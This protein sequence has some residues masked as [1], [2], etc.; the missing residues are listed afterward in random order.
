MHRRNFLRRASALGALTLAGCMGDANDDT[1]SNSTPT[2]TPADE[3]PK[4][5]DSS[6]ETTATGCTSGEDATATVDT[7]ESTLTVSFTGQVTAGTPCHDATI[8]QTEYD[9]D[10]DELTV[11]VGTERR[12]ETCVDCVGLIE[13]AGT[14]TFEGA[15]P[16]DVTITHGDEPLT[17]SGGDSST[18]TEL[19]DRSFTVESITSGGDGR[20]AD[21][22]FDE[23]AGTVVVTG[24][25]VGKDGCATAELGSAIY[26]AD[27][28][29]LH[30]DVVTTRQEGAE[31]KVCT[32]AL[33]DIDYE[34]TFTFEGE[35][36]SSVSISH[37]G[38]GVVSVG[39]DSSTATE[40]ESDSGTDTES[41]RDA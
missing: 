37:D 33:V 39:Y 38:Q 14:V 41:D 9:A 26:D 27:A 15:L 32:Q 29:E 20:T 40:S 30:V 4:V 17:G 3:K 21:A 16:G 13:F 2:P 8:E 5:V 24:T 23:D 22:T 12:D 35:I 1:G 7:D 28:D 10:A 25:I 19:I 31:D 18:M 11:E 6:I 34:A 36:P